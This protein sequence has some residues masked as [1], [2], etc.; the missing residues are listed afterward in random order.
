[1]GFSKIFRHDSQQ[2]LVI[3]IL[4]L[5][6]TNFYCLHMAQLHT[7]LLQ[8]GAARMIFLPTSQVERG[9]KLA[10]DGRSASAR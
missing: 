1:M 4:H 9:M 2:R 8:K 6:F 10:R 7:T 3:Y 5:H